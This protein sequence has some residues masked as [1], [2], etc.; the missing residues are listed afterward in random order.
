MGWTK[1]VLRHLRAFGRIN[2]IECEIEA[3]LLFHIEMRTLDNIEAGMPPETARQNA[4]K[5]FGNFEDMKQQ[6]SVAK[7]SA[8][9][10]RI[11]RAIKLLSWVLA[12][13]GLNFALLGTLETVRHSGQVLVAIAILLRLFFYIRNL[14]RENQRPF[15]APQE[16]ILFDD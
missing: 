9:A 2:G 14:S 3:E 12:L 15:A 1:T 10:V 5:Q 4:L 16:K 8:L 7:Q 13:S 11:S 6:C